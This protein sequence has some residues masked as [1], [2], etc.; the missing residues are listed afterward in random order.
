MVGIP[1]TIDNDVCYVQKTFGFETACNEATV[2]LKAAQ[3]E[4]RSHKYGVGLV[5]L[6]GRH[7]AADLTGNQNGGAETF[8]WRWNVV[9]HRNPNALLTV[10]FS[11][12]C[13]FESLWW[14]G[15]G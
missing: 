10:V 6:M 13:V 4:A 8:G 2:A 9:H 7:S 11:I 3:A 15:V 1:K 14:C 12:V 5:K